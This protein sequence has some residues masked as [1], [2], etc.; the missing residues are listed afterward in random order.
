MSVVGN[1]DLGVTKMIDDV[2]PGT[3]EI[4]Y[5]TIVLTNNG[6]HAATS[7]E[8]TDTWPIELNYMSDFASVGSYDNTTKKWDGF[9]L[10]AAGSATLVITGRLNNVA[11]NLTV[12]NTITITGLDQVDT[13]PSNDTDEAIL[14]S[15]LAIVHGFDVAMVGQTAVV[16]WANRIGDRD[17]GLQCLSA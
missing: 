13:D 1:V 9:S 5:Y 2:G 15:T 11:T 10:A 17:G 16:V 3:N 12:T 8:L 7:I 6:P 4:M 14:V